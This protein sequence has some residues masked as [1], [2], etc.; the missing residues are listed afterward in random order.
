MQRFRYH[1]ATGSTRVQ[2]NGG[3]ALLG[4]SPD[5][6]VVISDARV[7]R[8]HALLRVVANG[9]EAVPLV[10]QLVTVNGAPLEAPRALRDGDVLGVADHAFTLSVEPAAEVAE[11]D[12]WFIECDAGVLVAVGADRVSVGSGVED[13]L[14]IREWEPGALALEVVG[15]R[16]MLEVNVAGV[17]ADGPRAVGDLVTLRAG[18][19][20]SSR[21]AS[22]RVIS[23]P[24]DL[25]KPT[26]RPLV[27]ELATGLSLTFLPRGGNLTV[28]VGARTR[29][30]YL[31][32]RRCELIASL[33][34]PPQ[35]Y[36]VGELIPDEV[37]I[38]KLWGESRGG[39]TDLNTL[40]WRLRKD[41][42][43]A[44]LEDV[45]LFAR[46]NGGLRLLFGEGAPV[47]VRAGR[48]AV[49]SGA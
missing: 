23:L 40:V 37:I 9:I 24:A 43:E 8:H 38:A 1:L 22:F 11:P 28:S 36:G 16:L 18:S 41:L 5:C 7:S 30:V 14:V 13:R 46:M 39:R 48:A 42:A 10:R 47:T 4:R 12:P 26:T 27:D 21:G 2:L 44:G 25:S 6:D 29:K 31:A 19:E 20:V 33:M 17:V 45:T 49:T 3:S 32:D 15:G 34:Q 35:P